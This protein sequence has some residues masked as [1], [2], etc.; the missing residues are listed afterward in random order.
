MSD[1]KEESIIR[2]DMENLQSD[3]LLGDLTLSPHF[4]ELSDILEMES[5]MQGCPASH[6]EIQ[7]SSLSQLSLADVLFSNK[8]GD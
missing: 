1:L 4:K 6:Q 2:K 5:Q 3:V 7:D 8:V